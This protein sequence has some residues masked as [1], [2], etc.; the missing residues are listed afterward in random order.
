MEHR[1]RL[2]KQPRSVAQRNNRRQALAAQPVL[3]LE[4]LWFFL[5]PLLD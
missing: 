4:E 5:G 3:F 1:A 2:L